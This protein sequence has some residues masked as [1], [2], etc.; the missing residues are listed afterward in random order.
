M[1]S[2]RDLA[3]RVWSPIG[4]VIV[5]SDDDIKVM[6]AREDRRRFELGHAIARAWWGGG[7]RMTGSAGVA[8]E[9]GIRAAMGLMWLKQSGSRKRL[10]T[11]VQYFE[12]LRRTSRARDWLLG[13][14]GTRPVRNI[15]EVTLATYRA[16]NESAEARTEFARVTMHSWGK[17]VPVSELSM[18]LGRPPAS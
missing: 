3:G 6:T 5:L 9:V 16:L 10:E 12:G 1:V 13:F 8:S 2:E 14:T 4:S 15:A 7:C 17:Q 11:L 18:L